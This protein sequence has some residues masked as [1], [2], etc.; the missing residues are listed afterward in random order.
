MKSLLLLFNHTLTSSQE[1]YARNGLKV[2]KIISAPEN[3][4]SLWSQIPPDLET[5][6]PYLEPARQWIEQNAQSG[7]FVLVQ[8]DFGA[9][10]LMVEFA[11]QNNLI[12]IYSTTARTVVEKK[13]EDGSVKIEHN[14]SHVRYRQYGQ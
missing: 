2:D 6:F 13:L 3:I 11:R 10:F 12:P 5:L 8:G 1:E 4:R 7:D 14:F 9:T